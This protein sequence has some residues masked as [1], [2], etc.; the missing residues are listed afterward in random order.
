[1]E[2]MR[3]SADISCGPFE[4]IEPIGQGGMGAVIRARHRRDGQVAA[5][6]V[7]LPDTARA[8][9]YQ[10]QFR[11][12]VQALARLNHPCIATIYDYGIIG[13]DA[14]RR[15][16][17]PFVEGAPWLAM[18][19]IDGQPLDKATDGWNWRDL[20]ACLLSL[21]DALAHAHANDVVHRD[22]K[23]SN[24]LVRS[25]STTPCIVDFGIAAVLDEIQSDDDEPTR[26]VRGTPEFMA[27]E[28][29]LGKTAD[30]G[31]PTDLYAVGCLAWELLC[32]EPPMTG[33][34]SQDVID[35]QLFDLPTG[36]EP[37][38]QVPPGLRN[39]LAGLLSKRP[40]TRYQ[41]AA[42][43][44]WELVKLPKP[45]EPPVD[46]GNQQ[47]YE[48]IETG[49]RPALGTLS[50]DTSDRQLPTIHET[51]PVGAI[52]DP[53]TDYLADDSPVPKHARPPIP[54]TWERQNRQDIRPLSASGL[55]LFGLRRIPVVDRHDE[56]DALWNALW[57]VDHTG[58]PSCILLEGPA[59]SGKSKLAGWLVRRARE[60]GAAAGMKALHSSTGGPNEGLGPMLLRHFGLEG[61]S[62]EDVFGP[63]V[64]RLTRYGI[65]EST[66]L[67]DGDIL[68]E[69]SDRSGA[70]T[71]SAEGFV[72]PRERHLA[73]RRILAALADY[74]PVIL[75]LD[76]I[77]WGRS[78]ARFV[79]FLI[80]E[81]YDAPLPVLVVMTAR[82]REW[83]QQAGVHRLL[84]SAVSGRSGRRLPI[85]P[86]EPEHQRT[87]VQ[88][89]LR[90]APDLTEKLVR[91][92][93]GRPLFA[94]QLVNDWLNRDLLVPTGDGFAL[95]TSR[96]TRTPQ[97]LTDVWIR[98]MQAI[99][100]R[101]PDRRHDDIRR[102]LE[103]AAL[104]GKHVDRR[105]W[106]A[107]LDAAN[108]SPPERLVPTLVDAGLAEWASNG[109]KFIHGLLVD[110]LIS[111]A[112]SAGRLARHHVRCAQV[113]DELY[114][115]HSGRTAERRAEHLLDAGRP[116]DALEPLLQAAKSASN[117]GIYEHC[118]ALLKR[119]SRIL[120]DVPLP[121]GDRRRVENWIERGLN[122]ISLGES[123]KAGP[124]FSR[125]R[126]VAEHNGWRDLFARALYGI[127]YVHDQEGNAEE[128][129]E[130]I[131]EAEAVF[132]DID[133][134]AG[135]AEC[136]LHRARVHRRLKQ[137]A[138]RAEE[139]S[140]LAGKLFEALDDIHGRLRCDTVGC[141]S[142]LIRG[143]LGEAESRA[144]GLLRDASRVRNR[145][146]EAR[147]RNL[148]GEVAR[149]RDKL[150]V[151]REYYDESYSSFDAC[152]AADATIPA[153]NAA[154]VTLRNGDYDDA[155][156]RFRRLDERLRKADNDI[157]FSFIHLGLAVCAATRQDF[158]AC[159]RRV[160]MARENL[161][162][163]DFRELDHPELAERI[164]D[165]ALEADETER[166]DEMYTF[167]A[168]LWEALERNEEAERLRR[169][170]AD[171]R[172]AA[173][174]E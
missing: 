149:R 18:E 115:D 105:E 110:A 146:Y 138:Q 31:P 117:R 112:D 93:E 139:L 28:Q 42:D 174:R 92:T 147:A 62:K 8:G 169:K 14:A 141:V 118:A 130:N 69:N 85:E 76:D 79:E 21:L 155:R 129:L 83:N 148:L 131:A 90:F 103:L 100:G 172:P 104:L 158:R 84:E 41:C 9:E 39:W 132:D 159:D 73:L 1:M 4:L 72:Q 25:G 44:A 75:W 94:I 95:R 56:R 64:D 145:F 43:A 160:R 106:G 170:V 122:A 34:S 57:E 142:A 102:S 163:H 96:D 125:A 63:F 50:I 22:L 119:R 2:T 5:L 134:L 77:P 156:E 128:S 111:Q 164:G 114:D 80:D 48:R 88:R 152:G 51:E 40:W 58:T 168:D 78:S 49:D 37:N 47:S 46:D 13:A 161:A 173:H 67:F 137:N 98:R 143:D 140:R 36:F 12:E 19:F 151:A 116:E 7:L 89:L 120:D 153:F 35:S 109:W 157:F 60:L 23:P 82:R 11:A 65:D 97:D 81:G 16:P 54:D 20:R 126:Q 91:Q 154:L 26:E 99:L 52:V 136:M 113:L 45:D 166:A 74:R 29:I 121:E 61:P 68:L 24:L 71:S 32:G 171:I 86:L 27:P 6:K 66:A 108:L 3:F 162:S 70:S 59:G 123:S 17:E 15:G 150:H 127:A 124:L 30:Q 55:E 10:R 165:L 133:D 38:V 107:V 87:I 167:A 101:F 33:E 135:R 144:H 53:P